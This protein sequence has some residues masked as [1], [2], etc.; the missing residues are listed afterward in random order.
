VEAGVVAEVEEDLEVAEADVEVAEVSFGK[1][2]VAC[3]HAGI[4]VRQ[5]KP[6]NLAVEGL[7]QHKHFWLTFV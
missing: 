7:A 3:S 4:Q 2:D 6:V 5:A 1:D